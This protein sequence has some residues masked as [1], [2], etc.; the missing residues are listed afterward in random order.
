[1]KLSDY[2]DAV[3]NEYPNC[4]MD[5][6]EAG[7]PWVIFKDSSRDSIIGEGRTPLYA[8]QDAYIQEFG[9]P[10]GRIESD[11]DRDFANW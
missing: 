2:R 8:W 5:R 3:I 7:S 11:N 1:M 6:I 9:D 10:E 4:F